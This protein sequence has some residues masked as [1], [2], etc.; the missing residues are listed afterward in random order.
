MELWSRVSRPLAILTKYEFP[1]YPIAFLATEANKYCED[2]SLIVMA[3]HFDHHT[4]VCYFE[5]QMISLP[6]TPD[7]YVF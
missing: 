1:K 7:M 3:D 4:E 2:P 6:D 5:A